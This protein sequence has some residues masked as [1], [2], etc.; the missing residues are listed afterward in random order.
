VGTTKPSGSF[1]P[2]PAA[3]VFVSL[4]QRHQQCLKLGTLLL[5]RAL[6]VRRGYIQAALASGK[7]T[8]MC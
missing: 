2:F 5:R 1:C 3:V 8:L 4:G 7:L 6:A